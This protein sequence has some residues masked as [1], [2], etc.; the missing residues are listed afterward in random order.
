MKNNCGRSVLIFPPVNNYRRFLIHKVC[1]EE[2]SRELSTFSIGQGAERRT[3]VCYKEHLVSKPTPNLANEAVTAKRGSASSAMVV[4]RQHIAGNG[5]STCPE[6]SFHKVNTKRVRAVPSQNIYRP[7][8]A[9]RLEALVNAELS[10]NTAVTP[11]AAAK[12]EKIRVAKQRRPDIQV[13]VPRAKRASAV[14]EP[15][16]GIHRSQPQRRSVD[17][18]VNNG[19]VSRSPGLHSQWGSGTL[20]SP[21]EGKLVSDP[22]ASR[23]RKLECHSLSEQNVSVL[24]P[25]PGC[26]S[27]EPKTSE[28]SVSEQENCVIFNGEG[29][30]S[31]VCEATSV[32]DVKSVGPSSDQSRCRDELSASEMFME[33]ENSDQRK[34]SESVSDCER[35]EVSVDEAPKEERVENLNKS[36]SEFSESVSE[37]VNLDIL[38]AG[39]A[40]ERKKDEDEESCKNREEQNRKNRRILRGNYMSDV[41]IISDPEKPD[42]QESSPPPLPPPVLEPIPEKD[43]SKNTSTQVKK[44]KVSHK[45]VAPATTATSNNSSGPKLNPDEC[46]WDMLFDDNGE[47]LDPKLMEELTSAVGSVEIAKPQSNYDQY[48]TKS[49][50][51]LPGAED[52]FAHVVEIYNFPPEFKTQ[53]LLAVFSPYK[54]GGF[55]IKWVDDT[56]ALGVFSS[57][58]VA[59]DVL[60]TQH[61]FV[62]TRPL[63]EATPESRSKARRSAEFLQPYRTRPETCVA[64]ARRLVTASLGVRLNTSREE[65]EAERKMLREAREKKRLVARQREDA[66]EGNIGEK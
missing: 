13:Y 58:V 15:D 19:A 52:E 60:A 14:V 4:E 27:S 66:W 43:S 9:R 30:G 20:V 3:V 57:S 39:G 55:E 47:C 49:E 59:A 40:W 23:S 54:N 18:S 5:N 37:V 10:S 50:Q 63:R 62:K 16:S 64:L 1:E 8:A 22:P 56:H 11:P 34:S 53:D 32:P 7:P 12:T 6:Q 46:T 48:Q 38:S 36:C 29:N 33:L 65:R 45:P 35:V 44:K 24:V 2:S 17:I 41:L 31:S 21:S 61:P 25:T 28:K 26:S 51:F 42:K